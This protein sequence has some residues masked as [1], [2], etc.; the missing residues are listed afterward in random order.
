[1]W[2]MRQWTGGTHRPGGHA[3]FAAVLAMVA[4][5][6]LAFVHTTESSSVP[7]EQVFF[8]F[9]IISISRLG[10]L[11]QNDVDALTTQLETESTMVVL[12]YRVLV[13]LGADINAEPTAPFEYWVEIWYNGTQSYLNRHDALVPNPLESYEYLGVTG[14]GGCKLC[15]SS[16]SYVPLADPSAARHGFF[17]N[18]QMVGKY[19]IRST[20]QSLLPVTASEPGTLDYEI[21]IPLTLIG[22]TELQLNFT[23]ATF[24]EVYENAAAFGEHVVNTNYSLQV[25]G[26]PNWFQDL[27]NINT[28]WF[29]IQNQSRTG[30]CTRCNSPKES[31][32]DGPYTNPSYNNGDSCTESGG[33]EPDGGGGGVSYSSSLAL[34]QAHGQ[35]ISARNV[36]EI[37]D[38]YLTDATLLEWNS[39]TNTGKL[40]NGTQEIGQFWSNFLAN[41]NISLCGSQPPPVAQIG[42]ANFFVSWTCQPCGIASGI[43]SVIVNSEAGNRIQQHSVVFNWPGINTSSWMAQPGAIRCPGGQL[44]AR[45]TTGGSVPSSS[46]ESPSVGDDVGYAVGFA[47]F[48]AIAAIIAMYVYAAKRQ[49][50]RKSANLYTDLNGDL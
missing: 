35:G 8:K 29:S 24:F 45:T 37:L 33:N 16:A 13:S 14:I 38:G 34:L 12:D 21:T 1:M 10:V 6:L 50:P 46:S 47:A 3:A 25:V 39:A 11:Q 23:E 36:S 19:P 30:A 32:W 9:P 43:D 26:A 49:A 27:G 2:I 40:Y 5:A 31:F 18:S 20:F 44:E 15:P 42:P 28:V 22:P 41:F 4:T 17:I 48:G 7:L